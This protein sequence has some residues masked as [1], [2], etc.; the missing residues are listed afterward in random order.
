MSVSVR[1][2]AGNRQGVDLAGGLQQGVLLQIG[3]NDASRAPPP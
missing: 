1:D 3:Q 2:I